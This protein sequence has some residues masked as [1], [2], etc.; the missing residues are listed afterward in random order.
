[1]IGKGG[2][3]SSFGSLGGYLYGEGRDKGK[4][5]AT[6]GGE[7]EEQ[8]ARD[9]TYDHQAHRREEEMWRIR[10]V[11]GQML[12]RED[13][14]PR[15]ARAREAQQA[16]VLAEEVQDKEVQQDKEGQ[17]SER[18]EDR[19][20]G[21]PEG[22]ADRVTY[23][24]TRNLFSS[25][26]DLEAVV[27]EMEDVAALSDRCENP[28]YHLSISWPV[29]DR[30][31]REER[32]EAM[33]EVLGDIKL[34]DRQALFVEH[35]DGKPHLHAMVNRIQHNPTKEDFGTAWDD[36]HDWTRIQ[37]S[38]RRIEKERGWMRVPGTLV[39]TPDLDK[40][41]G[42]SLTQ[43]QVK[44][45]ERGEGLPLEK[46][47][48]VH[49]EDHFEAAGS[50]EELQK[51]L[52]A[53]GL[54]VER[55]KGGGVVRDMRSGEAVKLSSVGRDFSYGRLADRFGEGLGEWKARVPEA[56]RPDPLDPELDPIGAK[57]FL[58]EDSSKDSRREESNEADNYSKETLKERLQPSRSL[59]EQVGGKRSSSRE[60]HAASV[61]NNSVESNSVESNAASEEV[62]SEIEGAGRTSGGADGD[63]YLQT[64]G[65]EVRKLGRERA[66]TLL[67][68]TL[69]TAEEIARQGGEIPDLVE[70]DFRAVAGYYDLDAELPEEGSGTE[71]RKAGP[72]DT[73]NLKRSNEPE[74]SD[75]KQS[76]R[77]D[78][79]DVEKRG[80]RPEGQPERTDGKP[81][82]TRRRGLERSKSA[83]EEGRRSGEEESRAGGPNSRTNRG[84][85]GRD[86]GGDPGSS[87]GDSRP[88][89]SPPERNRDAEGIDGEPPRRSEAYESEASA[90]QA[91][92]RGAEGGSEGA[93]SGDAGAGRDDGGTQGGD[94]DDRGDPKGAEAGRG[95][96][97]TSGAGTRSGDRGN[98]RRGDRLGAEFSDQSDLEPDL[99]EVDVDGLDLNSDFSDWGEPSSEEISSGDSPEDRPSSEDVPDSEDVAAESE[100]ISPKGSDLIMASR[101][102]DLPA[103]EPI[104]EEMS[105]AEQKKV[106][107]EWARAQ[108]GWSKEWSK[109]ERDVVEIPTPELRERAEEL[110]KRAETAEE[111]TYD[112]AGVRTEMNLGPSEEP[113]GLKR[114]R[115][116]LRKEKAAIEGRID[117][118]KEHI[119]QRP[120]REPEL[121]EALET[122]RAKPSAGRRE[123]E[124]E[125]ARALLKAGRL[126]LEIE[127]SEPEPRG[128]Q[129]LDEVGSRMEA[130]GLERPLRKIQGGW[131]SIDEERWF[132]EAGTEVL[133][134]S[135][136]I[137][138]AAAPEY[139]RNH[140]RSIHRERAKEALKNL[141]EGE[142]KRV[143]DELMKGGRGKRKKYKR[144]EREVRLEE[145]AEAG[146]KPLEKALQRA[147]RREGKSRV[148]HAE[149]LDEAQKRF[150]EMERDV[151]QRVREN[152]SSNLEAKLE[153]A[154]DHRRPSAEE[155]RGSASNA[156][157]DRSG[158]GESRGKDEGEDEGEDE[159]Q[160]WEYDRGPGL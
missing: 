75:S 73:S 42:E 20:A 33:E 107:R 57:R 98:D 14:E 43:A 102:T 126:R 141:S 123:A 31:T 121:R 92:V 81:E 82:P 27:E 87:E 69:E 159:S 132:G 30:T 15:K 86:D 142:R 88:D 79:E 104:T 17:A 72:T 61:D 151:Q 68:Q 23:A 93:A 76:E 128:S 21:R 130:Y 157:S 46:Q 36:G 5:K 110:S 158:P 16:E 67:A 24:A 112:L 49:A 154:M 39:E 9:E 105:E 90:D 62:G 34:R 124:V 25:E 18:A 145:R 60:E 48:R 26:D 133:K 99:E 6:D 160:G 118:I 135:R 47:V 125:S 139:R 63:F 12:R 127:R 45:Y 111:A 56:K 147:D 134:A 22:A 11:L 114:R 44:M 148:R 122:V 94:R 28:V 10:E 143:R 37:E 120:D 65:K 119:R 97:R 144:V 19:A 96:V 129:L 150:E 103:G 108:T 77:P 149:A 1:M 100:P 50:W 51:S 137:A 74:R 78:S 40:E 4:G 116:A 80:P 89:P 152:L 138:H 153:E 64:L 71:V 155:I 131:S 38:L 106:A 59:H 32:I 146:R 70:K 58:E 91:E 117:E 8:V 35:G 84:L 7:A 113:V 156:K 140:P 109:E 41:P 66:E 55:Q 54:R 85:F 115:E 29:E 13:A 83:A 52:A 101:Q 3:R 2:S 136:N 95:D 53:Y